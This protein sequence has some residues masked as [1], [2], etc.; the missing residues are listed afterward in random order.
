MADDD[1]DM[2]GLDKVLRGIGL[3]VSIWII[4][5]LG[6]FGITWIVEAVR[7]QEARIGGWIVLPSLITFFGAILSI[8]YTVVTWDD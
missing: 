8:G 3:A 2:T 1:S 5:W 7:H 4:G 6:S